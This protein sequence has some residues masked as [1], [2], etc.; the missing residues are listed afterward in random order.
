M[1]PSLGSRVGRFCE[2]SREP[3]Q[4]ILGICFEDPDAMASILHS[5]HFLTAAWRNPRGQT[6]SDLPDVIWE[7]W[8]EN[9]LS[10][11]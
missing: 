10:N 6:F 1:V 4:D 2:N 9:T 8:T 5:S 3:A 11:K 7:L